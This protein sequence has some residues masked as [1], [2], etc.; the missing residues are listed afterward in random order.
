M[1]HSLI[2]NTRRGGYAL[3]LYGCLSI[4]GVGLLLVGASPPAGAAES[5][6]LVLEAKIPLGTV[7][8][9]IDHLAFDSS[10][11]YLYVAEL[12]ND[13]VGVVDLKQGK[14]ARTLT[15]LRHPQGIG[16][17]RSSD[18]VYVANAGDGSVRLFRGADLVP[19]GNILL[20]DDAD[21]V[22]VDEAGHRVFV[23][24][25]NG[26]LAVIDTTTQHKIAEIKLDAHPESF[27]LERGGQRIFVNVPDAGELSVVYRDGAKPNVSWAPSGLRANFP[28]ALD[29]SSGRVF[30]VFRH[31][32]RVGV[33]DGQSGR[34]LA[35]PVT[36]E[37][38]DDV[39][40]DSKRHRLYVI[41]GAGFIDVFSEA[42]GQLRLQSHIATV[43]GARTGL[44]V[45][46][47]DRLFLAVRAAGVQ[48]ASVWV[49]RPGS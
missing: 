41:C 2:S 40:F 13:S 43:G 32:P 3:A 27:Q 46:D 17:V 12:G 7:R 44:Y 18:T 38:S 15:G 48:G 19:A 33:I 36:C 1:R 39:F 21:N 6:A 20:G 34:L 23:G 16:Y 14:T 24:Y 4:F 9:R 49:F 5:A 42:G 45:A 37:D 28:L 47:L 25:G 26:A 31:P 22:R 11:Q 30:A 10:R 8:G 29:E 35:T